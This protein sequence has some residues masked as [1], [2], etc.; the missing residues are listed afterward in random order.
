ML[1]KA[2]NLRKLKPSDL[3]LAFKKALKSIAIGLQAAHD[4]NEKRAGSV[5]KLESHYDDISND[6]DKIV[7]I[8]QPPSNNNN[9][10][11]VLFKALDLIDDL[12]MQ[13]ATTQDR[14]FV[15]R[16]RFNLAYGQQARSLGSRDQ[17]YENL[18]SRV[19]AS[20]LPI[21]LQEEEQLHRSRR[22]A[23]LIHQKSTMLH[24]AILAGRIRHAATK[25]LQNVTKISFPLAKEPLE[26]LLKKNAFWCTLDCYH[27]HTMCKKINV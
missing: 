2:R 15:L 24:N 9:T 27:S 25:L 14:L 23:E 5:Q 19:V 17:A 16:Y 6:L 1:K 18:R 8:K 13:S 20:N 21:N 3:N 7:S 12:D 26:W 22:W 10:D 4:R 11:S